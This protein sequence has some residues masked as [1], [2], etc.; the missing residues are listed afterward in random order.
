MQCRNH[1]DVSGVNTCNECGQWFCEECSFERG[2]RIFC[3][4]CVAQQAATATHHAPAHHAPAAR[5]GRLPSHGVMFVLSIC[6]PIPG[7]NYM[8]MGLIKR[9]LAAMSA[10]FLIIYLGAAVSNGFPGMLFVFSIPVLILSTIFDSFRILRRMEAGEVV[11]DNIDDVMGFFRRNKTVIVVAIITFAVL[12]FVGSWLPRFF[13][14]IVP[15]I[16]VL[17]ALKLIFGRKRR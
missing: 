2:G 5:S 16:L 8:Y 13:G 14:N 11:T 15:V 3:P 17:L 1:P 10:F 6:V 12:Q 7:L 4:T 9:G